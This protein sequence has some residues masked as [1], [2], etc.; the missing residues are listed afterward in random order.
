MQTQQVDDIHFATH[1]SEIAF[2]QHL[3]FETNPLNHIFL[4]IESAWE[5]ATELNNKKEDL[6]YQIDGVVIKVDTNKITNV[7]GIVGKTPRC[8]SAIKFPSEELT[9]RILNIVWQVGRTGK[10]TPVAELENVEIGG[11]IVKRA[12]LHNYKEVSENSYHVLDTVVVRKAGEIIPEVVHVLPNLRVK[13]ATKIIVPEKCPSCGS[14]LK[15]SNTKIDLICPNSSNCKDQILYRL[16]YYASRN[17]ANI[18]GL[19]EKNLT[20]FIE[21]FNI[22]DIP[23]LYNLP[24]DDILGMEG[25]GGKSVANLVQS[26]NNAS[27][28]QDYKFLAGLGIDGVGPEIAKIILKKLYSKMQSKSFD[29]KK[30]EKSLTEN[31]NFLL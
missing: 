8:W 29:L 14:L 1:S 3:G 27:K 24:Y 4:D 2:L 31:E 19:S 16:S 26:I 9:T 13:E 15:F 17:I 18:D 28:I 25:F 10:L 21:K 7:A 12:T 5:Y 22:K 23:D 20:K 30:D 11:T 6:K